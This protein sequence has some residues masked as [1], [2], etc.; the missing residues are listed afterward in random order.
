MSALISEAELL[1]W[2]GYTQRAALENWLLDNRIPYRP[3]K[4]GK[5]CVAAADL[6]VRTGPQTGEEV[7]IDGA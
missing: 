3:G 6:P 7:R 4:G 5:L 2:T 1:D